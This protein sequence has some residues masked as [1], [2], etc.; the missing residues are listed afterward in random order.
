M[1]NLKEL[2]RKLDTALEKETPESLTMWLNS[3]RERKTE[4]YLGTGIYEELAGLSLKI[5]QTALS[6]CP[7]NIE[8]VD[9]DDN[10]SLSLAA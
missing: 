10:N 2:E 5:N 1:L 6:F 7:N 9:V 3:V 8:A 4:E